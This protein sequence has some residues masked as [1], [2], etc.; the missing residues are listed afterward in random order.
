VF[1]ARYDKEIKRKKK[2]EKKKLLQQ[3]QVRSRCVRCC[4]H[5]GSERF[6]AED[7]AEN[8][9]ITTRPVQP[10]L[11]SQATPP[12]LTCCKR[13]H[14]KLIIDSKMK[15]KL[16]SIGGFSIASYRPAT[17]SKDASLCTAAAAAA[18]AASH[19]LARALTTA[20][21]PKADRP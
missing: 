15:P 18:A 6:I 4:T 1:Q 21:P 11:S 17:K 9:Q 20:C 13:D 5:H 3:L 2:D 7:A 8:L 10:P 14:N 12:L 19:A 16:S